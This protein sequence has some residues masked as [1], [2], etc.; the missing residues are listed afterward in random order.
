MES[1]NSSSIV[2]I[3][4]TVKIIITVAAGEAVAVVLTSN[5]TLKVRCFAQL[6]FYFHHNLLI[7][8]RLFFDEILHL[9]INKTISST[10]SI[11]NV[12]NC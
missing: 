1:S 11:S 12:Y 5:I 6:T 4:V 10:L 8:L 3:T 2:V 9:R 7:S